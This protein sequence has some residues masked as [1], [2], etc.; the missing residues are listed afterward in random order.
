MKKE[1]FLSKLRRKL[2]VLDNNEIDD[3]I[4][5]YEGYI[6]EKI[7]AGKTEEEAIADFGSVDELAKELLRAY[8]INVDKSSFTE[9]VESGFN[10]FG[11]F[12]DKTAERI[13]KG[14]SK[15]I[16]TFVI[17]MFILLIGISILRIPF[18]IFSSLSQS[19]FFDSGIGFPVNVFGAILVAFIWIIYVVVS[20]YIMVNFFKTRYHKYFNQGVRVEDD[21]THETIMKD[22]EV[23][24]HERVSREEIYYG[25]SKDSFTKVLI[26]IFKFFMV[27]FMIP[28]FFSMLGLGFAIGFCIYLL[29]KGITYYGVFLILIGVFFIASLIFDIGC[30]FINNKKSNGALIVINIIVSITL[31]VVGTFMTIDEFLNTKIIYDASEN[32]ISYV[33]KYSYDYNSNFKL[34]GSISEIEF[35]I[36]ESLTDTINV[37]LIAYNEYFK[38]NTKLVER[39]SGV[40]VEYKERFSSEYLDVIVENL[41]NK[42]IEVF[43]YVPIIRIIS[44]SANIEQIRSNNAYRYNYKYIEYANENTESN[45][46]YY[47][48]EDYNKEN[49]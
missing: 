35:V 39:K 18:Q 27:I 5:E 25:E 30:R 16:F 9:Q 2:S 49:Y 44:S 42:E 13:G 23:R 7:A 43:R 36:D 38:N 41:K 45:G 40:Y 10:E 8:K 14:D 20:F 37:E 17:E 48:N 26:F 22:N 33:E 34:Y 3:I 1:E 6:D 24:K 12:I 11:K 21:E 47:N 46:N 15:D 29:V 31:M 32:T 19:I 4:V 28:V